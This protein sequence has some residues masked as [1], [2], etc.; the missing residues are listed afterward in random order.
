MTEKSIRK[1][2]KDQIPPDLDQLIQN[3]QKFTDSYFPPNN[4]SIVSKTSD[5]KFVDEELG[6]QQLKDMEEENPGSSK[7]LQWK[8]VTDVYDKWELFE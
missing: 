5:G 4:N 3:K 2:F 6:P 1:Y 8:R 7:R